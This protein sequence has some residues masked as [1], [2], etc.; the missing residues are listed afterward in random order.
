MDEEGG[1]IFHRVNVILC[2]CTYNFCISF[3]SATPGEDFDLPNF[4]IEA[5]SAI[6]SPNNSLCFNIFVIEDDFVE[7]EECF[8][9]GI[10]LPYSV[11]NHLMVEIS[12]DKDTAV[13]CIKDNDSKSYIDPIKSFDIDP[14]QLCLYHFVL[15]YSGTT[16]F[17]TPRDKLNWYFHFKQLE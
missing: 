1:G 2:E 15:T 4:S 12:E 13:V 8:E 5:I 7:Y 17:Q 14:I 9:V 6:H 3:I 11:S 10:S 16:L